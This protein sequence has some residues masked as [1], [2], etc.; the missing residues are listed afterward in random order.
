MDLATQIQR[1]IQ[2]REHHPFYQSVQEQ[3][4][5]W[6]RDPQ[7]ILDE[8][9]LTHKCM[10]TLN[11]YLERHDNILARLREILHLIEMNESHSVWNPELEQELWRNLEEPQEDWERVKRLF[12]SESDRKTWR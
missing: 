7:L 10:N 12:F 11:T 2:E 5:K 6:R 3:M 8:N 1:E 4:K 9:P